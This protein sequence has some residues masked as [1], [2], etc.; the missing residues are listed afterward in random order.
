[1]GS[2][3][4]L[5]YCD[6]CKEPAEWVELLPAFTVRKPHFKC[7]KHKPVAQPFNETYDIY[8]ENKIPCDGE[9]T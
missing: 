3:M 5:N 4:T 7:D 9:T 2:T 1:M 8:M 6:E